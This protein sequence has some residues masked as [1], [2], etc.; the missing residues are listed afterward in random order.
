MVIPPGRLVS[1][2]PYS[3]GKQANSKK[4]RDVALAHTACVRVEISFQVSDSKALI[5]TKFGTSC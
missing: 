3:S 1:Y 4:L 5:F 2:P